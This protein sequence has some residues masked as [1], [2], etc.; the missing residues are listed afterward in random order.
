MK[1]PFLAPSD[2][3]ATAE[4]GTRRRT[5]TLL[6]RQAVGPL[7]FAISPPSSDMEETVHRGIFRAQRYPQDYRL[8]FEELNLA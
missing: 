3:P 6:F 1:N 2:W 5:W 8:R 7:H 4:A